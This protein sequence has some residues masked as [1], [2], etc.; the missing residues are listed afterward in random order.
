L[1]FLCFVVSL[2]D[3]DCDRSCCHRCCYDR[4]RRRCCRLA[5][6]AAITSTAAAAAAAATAFTKTTCDWLPVSENR[7]TGLKKSN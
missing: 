4:Y 5:T 1:N 3:Q 6:I 7:A 2:H